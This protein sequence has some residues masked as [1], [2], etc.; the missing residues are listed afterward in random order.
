MTTHRHDTS[1]AATLIWDQA[2]LIAAATA[3]GASAVD[4]TT[5]AMWAV[6]GSP[7]R[8]RDLDRVEAEHVAE[9]LDTIEAY[10]GATIPE[11]QARITVDAD[12]ASVLAYELTL[13]ADQITRDLQETS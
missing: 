2:Y 10:L 5:S 6:H 9:L 3:R 11:Y 7:C 8:A 12:V 13:I 4:L 1:T